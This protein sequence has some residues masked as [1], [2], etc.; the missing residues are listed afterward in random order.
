MVC[1]GFFSIFSVFPWILRVVQGFG[2]YL[3]GFGVC[4]SLCVFAKILCYFYGCVGISKD[5]LH[6]SVDIVCICMVFC[7]DF[8]STSMDFVSF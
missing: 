3:Q 1:K 8:V 6:L 4:L 7:V 2:V 5:L